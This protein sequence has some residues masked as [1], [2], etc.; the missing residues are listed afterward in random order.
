MSLLHLCVCSSAPS[1]P[2]QQM[3]P[4]PRQQQRLGGGEAKRRSLCWRPPERHGGPGKG[5]EENSGIIIIIIIIIMIVV[6]VVVVVAIIVV[7]V[8]L[9]LA[10][11]LPSQVIPQ[12]QSGPERTRPPGTPSYEARRGAEREGGRP[13]ARRALLGRGAAEQAAPGPACLRAGPR[14]PARAA[15]GSGAAE[16]TTKKGDS[17]PTHTHTF[18]PGDS[19]HVSPAPSHRC[20]SAGGEGPGSAA[21]LICA[22]RPARGPPGAEPAAARNRPRRG[23]M[24]ALAAPSE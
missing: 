9:L 18:W 5:T 7:I 10:N 1:P 23:G 20:G 19:R 22:P 11:P 24:D 6:V 17:P 4:P 3:L 13:A 12:Q 14:S 15:T 21:A 8:I 16:T 2:A